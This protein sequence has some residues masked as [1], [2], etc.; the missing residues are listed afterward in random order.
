MALLIRTHST[1]NHCIQLCKNSVLNS[2]NWKSLSFWTL[3]MNKLIHRHRHLNGGWV[4]FI[5]FVHSASNMGG[6]STQKEKIKTKNK[7][8]AEI[9]SELTC[10]FTMNSNKK[11]QPF[12]KFFTCKIS[13]LMAQ[14]SIQFSIPPET[15]SIWWSLLACLPRRLLNY[16]CTT[17]LAADALMVYF[18][19]LATRLA[20]LKAFEMQTL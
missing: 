7:K 15:V 11:F 10:V 9:Y 19:N 13:E 18:Q 2:F 4:I 12:L 3:K 20:S 1:L 14:K 5:W 17:F 8:H 16:I 6:F